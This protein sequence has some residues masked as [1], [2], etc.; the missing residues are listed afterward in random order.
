M[1]V[2]KKVLLVDD[3]AHVRLYVKM[4]LRQMGV[5]QIVE[6]TSG[7]E[8]LE[9][10]QQEQPEAVLMD[11]NMPGMTGIEALQA[12]QKHNPQAIVVMLTAQASRQLVEECQRAGASYYIRKDTPRQQ[13]Q[14]LLQE[15][16]NA[17]LT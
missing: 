12:I 15:T 13:I 1:S 11:I 14:E 8:A 6:A 9:R 2:P 7:R 16:F 4:I 5:S 3:E 10:F 17:T